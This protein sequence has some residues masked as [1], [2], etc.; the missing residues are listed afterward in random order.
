MLMM[1]WLMKCLK[2]DIWIKFEC[3][4]NCASE[5][6]ISTSLAGILG[7]NSVINNLCKGRQKKKK[8]FACTRGNCKGWSKALPTVFREFGFSSYPA[9]MN[10]EPAP[11]HSSSASSPEIRLLRNF[12]VTLIR[13][14]NSFVYPSNSDGM[15]L[16][17]LKANTIKI[18][19]GWDMGGKRKLTYNLGQEKT[20]SPSLSVIPSKLAC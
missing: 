2:L 6:R 4:S 16:L 11:C 18:E 15:L 3:L 17:A 1:G 9:R 7:L 20:I 12:C 8:V 14:F 10:I 13:F 5:G 19:M